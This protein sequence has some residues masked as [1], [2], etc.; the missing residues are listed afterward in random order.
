[1]VRAYIGLGSNLG[2]RR[3]FIGEALRLLDRVPGVRVL[4][5]S[6]LRTTAP[7]GCEGPPF[8]NGVAEVRCSLTPR[9]LLRELQSIERRLGRRRPRR[10]APRTLDLDL[11]VFGRARVRSKGL[12]VPHPRLASRAFVLEPLSELRPRLRLPGRSRTIRQ[13]LAEVNA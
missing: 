12:T 3:K 8:L 2:D 7:E 9:A 10:R 13:L 4:R 1:M 6:R 11:L 5:R